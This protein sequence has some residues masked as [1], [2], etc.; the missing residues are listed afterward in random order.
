MRIHHF[1][2]SCMLVMTT[3]S[4]HA[5]DR[6]FPDTAKRGVMTPDNY[7]RVLIDDKTRQ[8]SAG[9]RIWN[10]D[11]L[12]EMPA[13]L[14]GEDLPVLYT[15]NGQGDIDRIWILTEDEAK[16]TATKPKPAPLP[17]PLPSTQLQQQ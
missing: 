8:L 4:A 5:F 2:L 1:L 7:P 15:E 12:I 6:P 3:L 13:A 9:S 17:A 11:N 14:R 10:Q 16:R